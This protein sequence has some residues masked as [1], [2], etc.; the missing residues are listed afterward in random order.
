MTG[1]TYDFYHQA[2]FPT[3]KKFSDCIQRKLPNVNIMVGPIPN[4]FYPGRKLE[5]RPKNLVLPHFYDLFSLVHKSF[6]N[7]TLDVQA[8]CLRR[9]IWEWIYFGQSG[10]KRN[11]TNQIKQII[12]SAEKNIGNVP[13]LIGEIGM[14]KDINQGEAFK[15][16]Y[17]LVSFALWNYSPYNTDIHGDGW[18]RESFSF[19]SSSSPK[20]SSGNHE[21]RLLKWI[22]RPYARRMAGLPIFTQ[23][24]YETRSFEFKCQN[25][26]SVKPTI[27]QT[28]VFLPNDLYKEKFTQIEIGDGTHSWKSDFQCLIWTLENEKEDENHWIKIHSRDQ[29]K[30]H[31]MNQKEGYNQLMYTVPSILIGLI[32]VW[33]AVSRKIK[34]T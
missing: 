11:Y 10:A 14:C 22:L 23:F 20:D 3:V 27:N 21:P 26:H 28:E 6:G 31:K 33:S 16:E 32:G 24:D 17:N 8:M 12:K 29:D 5:E 4:E 1:K 2:F 13:C 30:K 25:H 15:T 34:L 9:P 19:I 7:V 18:N